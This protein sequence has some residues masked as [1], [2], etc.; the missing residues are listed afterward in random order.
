V[1]CAR[2]VRDI[3]SRNFYALTHRFQLQNTE[4]LLLS[5]RVQNQCRAPGS[6]ALPRGIVQDMPNFE[7]EPLGGN[8]ERREARASKS[9]LAIPVGIKQKA[10]VHKLVSKVRA[11]I[12]HSAALVHL[13][14][15]FSI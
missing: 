14:D 6:E 12:D 2:S 8:P 3:I 4:Q 7:F 13:L 9:L 1:T 15:R 11:T 10:V 5:V